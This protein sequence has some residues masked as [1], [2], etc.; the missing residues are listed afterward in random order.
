MLYNKH[1]TH[2]STVLYNKTVFI[3]KALES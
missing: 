2:N 3:E 1:E